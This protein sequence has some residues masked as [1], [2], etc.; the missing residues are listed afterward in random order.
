MISWFRRKYEQ[1]DEQVQ[2][3]EG[4]VL[5]LD[6]LTPQ[7]IRFRM[8]GK[9]H[10][11]R[12]VSVGQF[13]EIYNGITKI[14]ALAVKKQL[15]GDKLYRAYIRALKPVCPTVSALDL[16]KMT[17]LQQVAFFLFVFKVISGEAFD[18][19]DL[20]AGSEKKN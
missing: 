11:A 18:L 20:A 13:G 10:E 8:Y 7:P 12:P 5:D 1:R 15:K 19:G 9:I 16:A 2:G 3:G 6:Q 14:D 17:R 4:V